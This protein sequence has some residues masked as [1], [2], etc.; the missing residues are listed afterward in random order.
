MATGVECT[1]RVWIAGVGA[2]LVANEARADIPR[3]KKIRA[4][5]EP[6]LIAQ[7]RD[8]GLSYPPKRA[9]LR[10]FK[11]ERVFEMWAADAA[12]T[13]MTRIE[14]VP[15]CAASGE[16][17]P[18]RRQGDEQV[19]EG[20]YAIHR[21]N[22]WSGFH[23]SLRVNYPNRSDRA[24]GFRPSLGGAIMVHGGCASIGCVAIENEAIERVFVATLDA[25]RAGKQQPAIHMLPT[26]FDAE[27]WTRLD[28]RADAAGE[29][30]ATQLRTL[31]RELE[32]VDAA[33]A[34]SKTIPT[35]AIDDHGAYVVAKKAT[36]SATRHPA[37]SSY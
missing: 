10:V 30:E 7:Y 35:V 21:Y 18:K 9:L 24:R 19:P 2:A 33:F 17:G 37:A 5:V 27:A 31:W 29:P 28:A 14:S 22:A 4:R 25:S 26:R 32:A 13:P 3:L 6:K 20:V 11:H 8:A 15:I 12:D 23:M 16:L 36:A 1:R 34:A